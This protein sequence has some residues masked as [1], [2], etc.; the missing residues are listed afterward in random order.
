MN[1]DER[2][3]TA[4]LDRRGYN[5]EDSYIIS[6]RISVV[7]CCLNGGE[8]LVVDLGGGQFD[9]LLEN[10]KTDADEFL[11]ECFVVGK[12]SDCLVNNRG[13]EREEE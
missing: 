2:S 10:L 8:K 13:S 5:L 7:K 4:V 12:F 11:T 3:R 6:G 1:G 9:C